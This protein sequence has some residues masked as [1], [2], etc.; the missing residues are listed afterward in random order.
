M[1]FLPASFAAVRIVFALVGLTAHQS[2]VVGIW[3]EYLPDD[4]GWAWK[5]N[6]LH[7]R[8]NSSNSS[9]YLGP[10]CP[11]H[12]E[13]SPGRKHQLRNSLAMARP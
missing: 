3:H 1:V 13:T 5:V 11:S 7:C 8:R 2:C 4:P 9:V 12:Q 6:G 10:C